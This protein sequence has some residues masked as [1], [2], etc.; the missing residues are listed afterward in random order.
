MVQTM[1]VCKLSEVQIEETSKPVGIIN[2]NDLELNPVEP[3]K[4]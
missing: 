3:E 2:R 4:Y 1:S